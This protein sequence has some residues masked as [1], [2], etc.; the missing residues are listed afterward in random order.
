LSSP[1]CITP[2]GIKEGRAKAESEAA[3]AIAKA[4]SEAAA[5]VA[6]VQSVSINFISDFC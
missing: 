1:F 2:Q 6:K 3:A 4:Q 5:A